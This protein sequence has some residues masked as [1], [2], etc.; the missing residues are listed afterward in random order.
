MHEE[1]LTYGL[2]EN[3]TNVLLHIDNELVLKGKQC[4]CICPNCRRPLI[5]RRGKKK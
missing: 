1:M 2:K 3:T 4:G 5:A